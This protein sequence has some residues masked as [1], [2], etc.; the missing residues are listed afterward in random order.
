MQAASLRNELVSQGALAH[1]PRPGNVARKSRFD[2][3]L[4]QQKPQQPAPVGK[5]PQDERT[6]N[7]SPEEAGT[8]G[9]QPVD[10]RREIQLTQA[11]TDTRGEEQGDANSSSD[12][13]R[14]AK[15]GSSDAAA[16]DADESGPSGAAIA[17]AAELAVAAP[18]EPDPDPDMAQ[19]IDANLIAQPAAAGVAAPVALPPEMQAGA[20]AP[21]PAPQAANPAI[22]AVAVDGA[23]PNGDG[24]LQAIADT[25]DPEPAQPQPGVKP[26]DPGASEEQQRSDDLLGEKAALL[27]ESDKTPAAKHAPSSFDRELGAVTTAPQTEAKPESP[28]GLKMTPVPTPTPEQKFA[29]DNIDQVVTSVKTQSLS[30]GGQM[31][32][33][34]DPPELGAL[35]VAVKMLEGR[36]TA[37]FTTSNE[38]A[39]QLLS[40]NLHQLKTSLEASGVN[41]DRIEVRQAPATDSSQNRSNSDPQQQQRGFDSQSQQGEQQRR[42]MVQRMW[43]KLAFGTDELDLVA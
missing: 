20:E 5:L 18:V 30:G 34:L 36:L 31:N 10:D 43:R 19:K 17:L 37:T 14:A 3:I 38:Q 27:P 4:S 40:H 6:I 13:P 28:H 1:S 15:K 9:T 29:H 11:A 16:K 25:M 8:A 35:Q 41:V 32:V 2:S 21:L 7:R 26:V 24:K 39:T 12:L 42:E 22:A 23:K 33:R